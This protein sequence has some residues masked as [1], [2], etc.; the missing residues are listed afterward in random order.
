MRSRRGR[1]PQYATGM[2]DYYLVER[3]RGPAWDDAKPRR[4]QRQWNEHGAFMD[5]LV[6]EGFV[7]LG[8]PVGDVDGDRALLVV[9]AHDETEVRAR[10]ADDPW[11]ED[12]LR[13]ESIRPWTIWLRRKAA[14][15][16]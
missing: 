4:Q 7:V 10:L 11:T 14:A 2:V 13:I 9:T 6:D 12:V 3:R 15:Q 16:S 1:R 8:G 5:A